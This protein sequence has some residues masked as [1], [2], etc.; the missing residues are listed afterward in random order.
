MSRK[1]ISLSSLKSLH[2]SYRLTD[3]DEELTSDIVTLN[4]GGMRY[5]TRE[6][7]LARFPNTL[8][9][10]PAKR[11]RFWHPQKEEFFFDRDRLR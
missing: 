8:L 5:Q 2:F 4:V 9:G 1:K 7:V 3:T 10:N 11:Y 6:R